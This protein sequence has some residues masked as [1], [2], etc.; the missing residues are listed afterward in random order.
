MYK[1]IFVAMVFVVLLAGCAGTKELSLYTKSGAPNLPD[2]L[3]VPKPDLIPWKH[4]VPRDMSKL[5][6]ENSA[7]CKSVPESQHNAS[8]WNRCGIHPPLENSNIYVG[9]D[10]ANWAIIVEDFAKL[11]EALHLYNLRINEVNA[12]RRKW[13]GE[14]DEGTA[15]T[16]QDSEKVLDENSQS[17]QSGGVVDAIKE[18]F[19]DRATK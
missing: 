14:A 1:Q 11:R 12:Q 3:P 8:F 4:D 13:R 10:Q 15:Q 16:L 5:V 6:V 17:R 7:A 9:F 2:I 19:G 18:R